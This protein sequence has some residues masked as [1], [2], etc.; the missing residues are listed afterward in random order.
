LTS[1][2]GQFYPYFEAVPARVVPAVEEAPEISP[3]DG[4]PIPPRA[5]HAGYGT[6]TAG[7]LAC[8]REHHRTMMALIEQSGFVLEDCGRIL[9]F[10]CAGG[11]MIRCFKSHADRHEVW[12]VDIRADHVFW[13][14]RHLSPPFRFTTVTTHPHLPFE[15]NS[16]S[17][18]YACSV[19]T[20]IG[21]LED[22]WLL[23]LRRIMRPRGRLFATVHDNHTID[24]L[25][26]SPPGHWLHDQPVRHQ[27]LEL[28]S[29][30]GILSSGFGM[31]SLTLEPG[32]HQ[33]FHD[34]EFLRRRWGQF[35]NVLSIHPEAHTYQS[36][37]VLGK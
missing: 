11:R 24:I 16:F 27:V 5:L 6:D 36:A 2:S 26:S 34:R 30:A 22:T 17:F 19:F 21:D 10:G 4:L 1:R 13:C 8:G 7:Y 35:F 28:E 33:V 20:H 32:N 15:D 37:V 14:Q 3:D 18:I 31:A 25:A 29:Q 23:E 9:D 12:G